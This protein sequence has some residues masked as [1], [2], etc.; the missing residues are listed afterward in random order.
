MTI[1][2]KKTN[3]GSVLFAIIM[4]AAHFNRIISLVR[5]RSEHIVVSGTNDDDVV[6]V[7][8]LDEYERLLGRPSQQTETKKEFSENKNLSVATREVVPTVVPAEEKKVYQIPVV[9]VAPTEKKP[10]TQLHE[11]FV[12][13]QLDFTDAAWKNDWESAFLAE[14]PDVANLPSEEEEEKFYLEPLE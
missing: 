2:K 5:T 3:L 11:S 10:T 9:R 7:L 13:D 6:V 14:H 12:S 8:S 4:N 1:L